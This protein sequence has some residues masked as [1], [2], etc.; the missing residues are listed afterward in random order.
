M[1]MERK[2]G[3]IVPKVVQC[4]A[5]KEYY[6]ADSSQLNLGYIWKNKYLFWKKRLGGKNIFFEER[7]WWFD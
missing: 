3:H 1:Y 2:I 5:Y 4:K 6:G 7:E